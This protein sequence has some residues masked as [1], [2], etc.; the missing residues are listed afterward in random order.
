[1]KEEQL[2]K[3]FL[4]KI[5]DEYNCFKC[6]MIMVTSEEVFANAYKIDIVISIYEILINLVEKMTVH[7]MKKLLEI[8]NLLECIYAEW[9]QTEDDFYS[10]ICIS[11]NNTLE[12]EIS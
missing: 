8:N 2:K 3:C 1:M 5:T 4:Q 10:Q 6:S 9:L 12:K 7:K 11:L